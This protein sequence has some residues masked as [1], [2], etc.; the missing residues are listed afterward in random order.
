LPSPPGPALD[1]SECAR[2]AARSPEEAV[3]RIQLSASLLALALAAPA[4]AETASPGFPA[5]EASQAAANS[6]PG[7]RSLPAHTVPVPQAD[8]SPAV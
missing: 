4:L 2:P 6:Q 7:P 8:V 1:A 3:I 5:L